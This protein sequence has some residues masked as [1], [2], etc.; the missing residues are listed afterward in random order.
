MLK[1][2]EE[3]LSHNK[4]YP[5]PRRSS[6]AFFL[7]NSVSRLPRLSFLRVYFENISRV[8]VSSF[9]GSV[10]ERLTGTR[11]DPRSIPANS[12]NIFEVVRAWFLCAIL[13]SSSTSSHN[14]HSTVTPWSCTVCSSTETNVMLVLY[15]CW[16]YSVGLVPPRHETTMFL[17]WAGTNCINIWWNIF[18][19]K[20]LRQ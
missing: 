3:L 13:L 2:E 1:L 10:V 18:L 19:F 5:A 16:S 9:D 12:K 14:I 7:S 17:A 4:T 11:G 6:W 8:E 15:K 20:L